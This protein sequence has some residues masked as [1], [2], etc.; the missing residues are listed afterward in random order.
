MD[1][2][3][4]ANLFEALTDLPCCGDPTMCGSLTCGPKPE[5]RLGNETMDDVAE[6][7]LPRSV[8]RGVRTTAENMPCNE[9][10]QTLKQHPNIAFAGELSRSVFG[11]ASRKR[12]VCSHEHGLHR[13]SRLATARGRCCETDALR[14]TGRQDARDRCVDSAD[15]L[16]CNGSAERGARQFR[17][18]SSSTSAVDS[19]MHFGRHRSTPTLDC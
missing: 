12:R 4:E 18:A 15:W 2:E 5:D 3:T 16:S 1:A 11:Q 14:R 17:F 9:A 10:W 13:W 7:V 19:R 6:E 8:P